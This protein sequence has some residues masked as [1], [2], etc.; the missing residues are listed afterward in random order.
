M[1]KIQNLKLDCFVEN[2]IPVTPAEAGVQKLV[3]L[4]G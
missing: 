2:P 1:T 4:A 3:K